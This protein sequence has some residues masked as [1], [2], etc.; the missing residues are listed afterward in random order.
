MTVQEKIKL[1]IILNDL[2]VGGAQRV[3][4]ELTKNIDF[5]KY[6]LTI[7][8]T[9]GKTNSLLENAMLNDSISK[10]SIIFLKK[11]LIKSRFTIFNKIFNKLFRFFFDIYSISQIYNHL[12]KIKPEII[13]ANQ[14]GIWAA[15][16][17]LFNKVP[18]LTTIHSAPEST[19]TRLTERIILHLSFVKKYNTLVA[20]SKYNYTLVKNFWNYE[21]ICWINNGINID[22]FYNK[23]HE[24]FSFINV[25]R[26]D[27]NKNQIM[28]INAFYRLYTENP[29]FP[30]ILYLIGGGPTHDVLVRKVDE[31]KLNDKIIFTGNIES[32]NEYYSISDVYL[33]SSH[34]EGLSLSALEALASGLPIISTA[35]GG[36]IELTKENGILIEDNDENGLFLAMKE[37]RDNSELRIAKSK[38]SIKIIG[39][40]SS[41]KMTEQYCCLYDTLSLK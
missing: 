1:V 37:L 4:Y 33:S 17:A 36:M 3:I 5:E 8:C 16:W 38:E 29:D 15:W 19:N 26:H 40:Y 31:Y 21:K 13:H 39:E 9:D 6:N 22:A 32:P 27:N 18:V 2:D 11:I 30:M 28:I 34:R 10:Y 24:V 14:N 12:K 35:V 23:P 20:I 25:S 41:S 7:I